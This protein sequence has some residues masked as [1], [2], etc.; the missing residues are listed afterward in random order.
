MTIYCTTFLAN[1]LAYVSLKQLIQEYFENPN[2]CDSII[3]IE[4]KLKLNK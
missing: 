4:L 1:A 2:F 3:K